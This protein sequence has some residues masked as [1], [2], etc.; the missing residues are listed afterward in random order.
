VFINKEQYFGKV[1]QSACGFYNGRYQPARKWLKDR[2]GRTLT[3]SD[4]EH[5]QKIIMALSKNRKNNEGDR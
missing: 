3:N 1:P 5:Y 4:I 2:K